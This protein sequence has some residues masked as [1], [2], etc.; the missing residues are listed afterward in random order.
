MEK[1]T[2]DVPSMYADH[3]VVEVR[4]IL[5]EL[6]GVEEVY[7]SSSFQAVEITYDP[8][9]ISTKEIEACLEESGYL[10]DFVIPIEAEVAAYQSEGTQAY[11]RHTAVYET[12]QKAVS[13]SQNVSYSGRPLWHCPGM[14]VI[15][16]EMED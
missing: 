13:F 16:K 3:H 6:Q 14:G 2:I 15:H 10:G 5:L 4:R 12:S 1:I 11:F 9:V 8:N 7:A